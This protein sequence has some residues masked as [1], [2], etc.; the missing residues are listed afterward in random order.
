[1]QSVFDPTPA[2]ALQAEQNGTAASKIFRR[3]T[4]CL[5]DALATALVGAVFV[6]PRYP[7]RAFERMTARPTATDLRQQQ[8]FGSGRKPYIQSVPRPRRPSTRCGRQE[9]PDRGGRPNPFGDGHPRAL[10]PAN[11][12]TNM[13]RQ[14]S[15]GP[16]SSNRWA[17]VSSPHQ[18]ALLRS[19]MTTSGPTPGSS[20]NAPPGTRIAP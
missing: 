12:R 17:P 9:R 2:S 5:A 11:R 15:G 14:N 19:K 10:P 4:N 6:L 3:S 8:T 16:A 20:S 7:G 18:F 13:V 1:M